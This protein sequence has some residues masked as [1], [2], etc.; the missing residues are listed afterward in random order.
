MTAKSARPFIQWAG[1]KRSVMG[2]LLPHIPKPIKNYYEP[3]LG[4]G[5]LFFQLQPYIGKA[6]LSDVNQELITTYNVVKNMPQPLIEQL[7][8]H[9]QNHSRDYFYEQVSREPT[10]PIQIAARMLYLNRTC[11]HGLY[12]LNKNGKFN[13]AIGT[14]KPGDWVAADNLLMA[15]Q[16]LQIAE[17][18][19]QQFDTINPQA[20]DFVYL[21]PPY[22]QSEVHY[23]KDKFTENDQRRVRDFAVQLR[24]RGVNVMLSNA[25]TPFIRQL[26]QGFRLKEI[27]TRRKYVG[28]NPIKTELLIH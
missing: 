22:H 16:A 28:K 27:P 4:G 10:N 13:S 9:K 12:R 7:K 8:L 26:Y 18:T 2:F 23:I 6:Y 17:I 1:G 11:H 19:A 14:C 15:Q 25:N 3:F 24:L 21:D 20:G 5:A